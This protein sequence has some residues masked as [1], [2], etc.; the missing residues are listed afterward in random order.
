MNKQVN[1][2][3]RARFLNQLQHQQFVAARSA[4]LQAPTNK[5]FQDFMLEVMQANRVLPV[6]RPWVENA[7]FPC[8]RAGHI[9]PFI[10]W[11]VQVSVVQQV[12]GMAPPGTVMLQQ[13]HPGMMHPTNVVTTTVN[14]QVGVSKSYL[15]EYLS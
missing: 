7:A 13:P 3:Y 15:I 5:K 14:I 1:C 8:M 12:G 6:I 2:S 9:N 4:P 11:Q 10:P